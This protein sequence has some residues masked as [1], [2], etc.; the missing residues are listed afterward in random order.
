MK[1]SIDW[2]KSYVDI[3]IPIDE[4]TDKLTN[5]GFNLEELIERDGDITLDLEV[6]SN[7]PD[8]LGHIG[9]AREIATILEKPLKLP[10]VNL[11]EQSSAN[12]KEYT[13]VNVISPELC[14]RYT[15]RL[16]KDVQVKPSPDWLVKRLEAVGLRSVNNIVDITNYVLFETSQPLHAFD[17]NKLAGR[18]I[19]VRK[20]KDGEKFIAIDHTEHKLS[21]D[22]LIIAD[23]EKPV[24]LAGIMGGLNTEV[25]DRTTDILLESAQF[26]P[27]TIRKTARRVNLHSESSFRFERKV[28][29]LNVVFA[30]ERAAQLICEIANG[31]LVSGIIDVWQSSFVPTEIQFDCRK[32][33]QVLGIDVPTSKCKKILE[34]LGIQIKTDNNNI[35]EL[36]I[37]SH[38]SD[39]TRPIDIV[40]EIARIVGLDKIPTSEKISIT[41]QPKSQ[42][43]K[44]TKAA[45]YA[46]NH[47]GY[48]ETITVTLVEPKYAAMFTQI[49]E[50]DVLKLDTAQRMSNNALRCSL[51]PSLLAV[52]KI[53]QDAGNNISDIYEIAR[54]YLPRTNSNS[55]KDKN[56]TNTD[57]NK[58]VTNLPDEQIHLAILSSSANIRSIR[59]VLELLCKLI[60]SP[61]QITLEPVE[62]EYFLPDQSAKLKLG[63]EEIGII[64]TVN[65]DIQKQFDI[66]KPVSVAE[67]N[68]SKFL[69]IQTSPP[70]FTPIEKYPGIRRDFSIIV[71]ERVKW[72]DIASAIKQLQISDIRDI[73]FGEMFRGKQI[74]KGKKSLFF[75][76]L[77][78][79]PEHSLT[80]E[81]ADKYQQQIIELLESKFDAQLRTQ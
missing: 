6:T 69:D 44:I 8:C 15:A 17:F 7:R 1:V 32:V 43:E 10:S 64:G 50:Q 23:A 41:T 70:L 49:N 13:S 48:Y 52:R 26:D 28:D 24:A 66:K 55:N 76:V 18:K 74:P 31:K 67:I 25:T 21:S 57:N 16:I 73:E 53:N 45:H 60:N 39:L 77:F 40:E 3:D 11:A 81:Q 27:I 42:S 51:I 72:Q 30:S 56:N 36:V 37:P 22:D 54:V 61:E 63:E 4:L 38:R 59:G 46:L 58:S 34:A 20:A 47:C 33:K 62:Y 78:R 71:D 2:L 65:Q 79:N 80:H 14:P 68:F 9:I 75:S 12:I 19:I 29:P 35:L 5:I